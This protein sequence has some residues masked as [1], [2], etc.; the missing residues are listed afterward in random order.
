MFANI[1][2]VR[3]AVNAA[4][5]SLF[6]PCKGLDERFTLIAGRFVLVRQEELAGKGRYSRHVLLFEVNREGRAMQVA[7]YREIMVELQP[8]F[9][10]REATLA[11]GQT[12]R[13]L[14]RTVPSPDNAAKILTVLAESLARQGGR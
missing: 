12:F 3:S 5:G 11:D 4:R 14:P 9:G 10:Y 1:D 2:E 6:E 8:G 7:S 13:D